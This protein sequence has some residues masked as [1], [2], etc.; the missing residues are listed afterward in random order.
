MPIFGSCISTFLHII[1]FPNKS[2][3]ASY[4]AFTFPRIQKQKSAFFD[5]PTS[6]YLFALSCFT[7]SLS[8]MW[9]RLYTSD[10]D[11]IS[12]NRLLNALL[13]YAGP[14]IL[15]I[16]ESENGGIFGAYSSCTWKEGKD[17]YGDSDCFLFRLLPTL[18]IFRARGHKKHY[19]Y[20]NPAARSKG[21]DELPH[22]IGF[23][24]NFKQLRLF[25][26]E[27]FDDCIASSTDLTYEEGPLLPPKNEQSNRNSTTSALQQY[28][29]STN[30]R[31]DFDI[32]S[33]EV[34]G[35]GGDDIVQSALKA[36]KQQRAIINDNIQKARKV[37]KAQFLDDFNNG[38]FESKAFKHKAQV[39]GHEVRTGFEDDDDNDN[40]QSLEK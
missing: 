3:P 37:D 39:H 5:K 29:Q 33:L 22:G 18:D 9:Y 23:G 10:T 38:T 6:S 24:G 17:F 21:Y 2:Y 7:P 27:T 13:G 25:L 32:H 26:S 20:C 4:T 11:G 1:L 30:K 16:K 36:R 28:L 34:W 15:L 19:V 8:G 14:T 31:K 35:V 12:F 40:P